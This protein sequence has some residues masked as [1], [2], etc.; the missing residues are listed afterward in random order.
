MMYKLTRV[1]C[2]TAVFL[3]FSGAD[4][5]AWTVLSSPSFG[6]Q[7]KAPQETASKQ[8]NTYLLHIDVVLAFSF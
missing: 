6:K 1:L 3:C 4:F 8:H 2:C 5:E 7:H